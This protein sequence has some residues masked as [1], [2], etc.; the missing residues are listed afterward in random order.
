MLLRD[1]LEQARS[2]LATLTGLRPIAVTSVSKDAQGWRVRVEM[3]EM[4]RVPS[5]T[6]I[7]GDYEVLFAQDGVLLGFERKGMRQ[8]SEPAVAKAEEIR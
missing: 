2:E 4:A 6:D 7:L 1:V 8:R 3:L 5:A